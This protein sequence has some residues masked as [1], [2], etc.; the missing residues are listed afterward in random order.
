M[1]LNVICGDN[2]VSFSAKNPKILM[3][4]SKGSINITCVELK[5][6]KVELILD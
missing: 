4:S 5:I 3:M 2:F 1:Y 6:L